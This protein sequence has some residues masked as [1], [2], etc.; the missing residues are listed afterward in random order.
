LEGFPLVFLDWFH[1]DS[2]VGLGKTAYFNCFE[3]VE[4]YFFVQACFALCS[5][6]LDWF[7]CLH[8]AKCPKMC[9]WLMV[10][11]NSTAGQISV[12]LFSQLLRGRCWRL[13]LQ[14]RICPFCFMYF[15]TQSFCACVLGIQCLLGG[16]TFFPLYDNPLSF[17]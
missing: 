8:W 7:F 12:Q 14:L 17:S 15:G 10:L 9:F 1:F 2:V 6:V 16:L 11:W 4:F 5:R 13:Q 3:F